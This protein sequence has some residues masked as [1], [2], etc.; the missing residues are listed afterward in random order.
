MIMKSTQS[1]LSHSLVRTLNRSHPSLICIKLFIS[2]NQQDNLCHLKKQ[3]YWEGWKSVSPFNSTNHSSNIWKLNLEI[4]SP[5]YAKFSI[6]GKFENLNK[7]KIEIWWW[8]GWGQNPSKTEMAC[9]KRCEDAS[10]NDQGWLVSDWRWISGIFEV[11]VT[12]GR[13]L[14]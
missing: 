6:I 3:I 13:T 7:T 10:K 12:D 8:G 9:L 11:W 5:Q 1:V 2:L 4:E 14:L